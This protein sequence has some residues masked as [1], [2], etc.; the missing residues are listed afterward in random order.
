VHLPPI[1][2]LPPVVPLV[3]LQSVKVPYASK[4]SLAPDCALIVTA[5]S[6]KG[7][8]AIPVTAGLKYITNVIPR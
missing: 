1:P 8:S 7:H 2:P 6:P 3:P 5:K 4:E